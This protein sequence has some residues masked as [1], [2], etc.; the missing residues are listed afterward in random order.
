[1]IKKC[2]ILLGLAVGLILACEKDI[3][4]EPSVGS[5]K[6]VF[7]EGLLYPGELPR[8]YVSQS[9][10]FFDAKITPQEVFARGAEVRILT[11]NSTETL[12]P[13]S[14]F[15]MFRCRWVPFYQ[16][17]QVAEF[18]QTYTLE[19]LFEGKTYSATTTI[20]QT[21]ATI[22]EISYTPEF[23]DLYGGHDGV[24]IRINDADGPGNYYR[25][26]MNR[27]ID[28]TVAHAHVL[29]VVPNNCTGGEDFRIT[30]LG[31]TIFSD[32]GNDG[33][34]LDLLVEVSFEYSQGDST[35][36]SIQSLDERSAAFYQE[37]D[38]QLISIL[39]PFV[40]PVFLESE[41]D[42]GA[43]G[44]FGSVVLSDSV[45]FVYPQDNPS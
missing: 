29:E 35:W 5:A 23:T 14:T 40:E 25:F 26:Q 42:G 44:V 41:I 22:E 17:T 43:I 37:L 38:D 16:G 6:T 10:P 45:L 11:P 2:N 27:M 34:T 36:I 4:I 20:D 1:M 15:D 18:G 13:D 12:S 21:P 32:V 24:N 7:I 33:A 39:N 9:V 30:D 19:V 31:R 3:R 8:I 28:R